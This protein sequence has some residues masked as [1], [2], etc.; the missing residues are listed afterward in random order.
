MLFNLVL[1]HSLP[2]CL[3]GYLTPVYL[4]SSLWLPLTD[5]HGLLGDVCV[6]NCF[7]LSCILAGGWHARL[8]FRVLKDFEVFKCRPI[9][10]YF[11]FTASAMIEAQWFGTEQ[12]SLISFFGGQR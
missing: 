8:F 5:I 7:M 9:D 2:S 11:F 6:P 1:K 10:F 4:L 12:N 3:S